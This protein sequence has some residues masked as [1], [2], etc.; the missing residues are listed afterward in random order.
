MKQTI[1]LWFFVCTNSLLAQ[2]FSETI[3]LNVSSTYGGD[4]PTDNS[5]YTNVLAIGGA[6]AERGLKIYKQSPGSSPSFVGPQN[7]NDS[8]VFEMTDSN[9]SSPDGGI[10]FGGTGNTDVFNAIMTIR[11]NGRVG[12]GTTNPRNLFEV[13]GT[14]RSKEVKVEAINWPDYVFEKA[15]ELRSLE[16]TEAFIKSNKHLPE[17]PSAE[18][19][20][21]NGVQLG[22]M[23]RLLLQKIEELTLHMIQMNKLHKQEI[24]EL[25]NQIQSLKSK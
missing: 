3:N 6:G 21:A 15:Y 17:I 11:G 9:G 5:Y 4:Y 18:D 7:W 20:E 8:Y 24:E 1:S 13:N 19:I 12:I 23:N 22:E 14:I 25:R 2:T 10:V 16:E